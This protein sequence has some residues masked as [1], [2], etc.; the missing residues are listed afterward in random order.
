MMS[1]TTLKENINLLI[2]LKISQVIKI[3]RNSNE[4]ATCIFKITQNI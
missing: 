1:K 4:F 3:M 2:W